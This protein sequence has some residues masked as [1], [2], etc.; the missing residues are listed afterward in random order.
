MA[1]FVLVT[2]VSDNTVIGDAGT[3]PWGRSL[4]RDLARFKHITQKIGT[5]LMGRRTAE[6]LLKPLPKRRNLVLSRSGYARAGFEVF[7]SL[8]AVARALPDSAIAVIGGGEIYTLCAPYA[9]LAYVTRIH[10]NF[11]GNT[12]LDLGAFTTYTRKSTP[13][14]HQADE[15]NRYDITFL[16]LQN[17]AVQSIEEV[18][19]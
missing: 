5:V 4:P 3:L 16:T 1:K 2:A 9:S 11:L 15:N 7:D 19:E 17:N 10:T 14:F 18:H 6:S 12:R 8:G 13:E